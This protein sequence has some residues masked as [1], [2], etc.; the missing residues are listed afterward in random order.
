VPPPSPTA[1]STTAQHR[2]PIGDGSTDSVIQLISTTQ[3]SL[4]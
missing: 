3:S 2:D 4:S 1:P